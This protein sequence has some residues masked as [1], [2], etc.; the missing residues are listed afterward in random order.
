VKKGSLFAVAENLQQ[1]WK[2]QLL[3]AVGDAKVKVLKMGGDGIPPETHADFDEMLIV[4]EGELP[5]VVD[6][7]RHHLVAGDF[8]L[9]PKGQSHHVPAGS[10]GT[11][12]I[13]DR[14][15]RPEC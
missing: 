3:G 8:F 5:L 11:L 2:S 1:V 10:A 13:I 4:L 14:Q 7:V 6:G 9:I 15:A 12:L